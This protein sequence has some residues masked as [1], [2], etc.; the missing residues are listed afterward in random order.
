M[1]V[2]SAGC[3]SDL[4]DKVTSMG[5]IRVVATDFD[6]TVT[7]GGTVSDNVVSSFDRLR[8]DGVVSVLVTGRIREELL[9]EYPGVAEVFDAMVVENGAVAVVGQ[10]AR[11]L[12][13]PVEPDVVAALDAHGIPYRRGQVLL[14]TDATHAGAVLEVI[15]A[16]G[17]DAQ[18]IHNRGQLMVL[19]AGV[20]KGT[21][22]LAVLA[23]LGLSAHNAI[24]IGDAENDLAM[25]EVAEVGVA[26]ANAVPSVRRHADIVLD[27][28]NGEGLAGL[29]AGSFM[30][31]SARWCPPRRWI[32]IGTVSDG[33]VAKV[34]GSQAQIVVSGGSGCG[35]SYLVGLMVE[36]WIEAGYSVLV[37]DPEGDHS[38]LH[39]LHQVHVVDSRSGLPDPRDLVNTLFAPHWSVVVDLSALD[40]ARKTSYMQALRVAAEVH[41]EERGFP[42]W[43][44]VDEAHLLGD[45]EEASW[46]RR[47]GYL[48]SSWRPGLM[49]AADVNCSGI[50][51]DCSANTPPNERGAPSSWHASMTTGSNDPIEFTVSSR[52]TNHVRHRRKYVDRPLPSERRFYFRNSGRVDAP[53][54]AGD[55]TQFRTAINQLSPQVLEYHLGR[56]D[57]SRW[58]GGTIGDR[59]L[60]AQV[61]EWE[62]QLQAH[63]AADLERIRR[64]VVDAVDDRYLS[65]SPVDP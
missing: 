21:G 54:S 43:L 50:V 39:Q 47:G 9:A 61:G 3:P 1:P 26:V 14:A 63:R 64:H 35:K 32:G 37:M 23:D 31:G 40:D 6:G 16:E 33:T 42:H 4:E 45:V 7:T 22:L 34:P 5:F 57:F 44:V 65:I 8:Q 46:M 41:R 55:I 30:T 49:P 52:H 38:P 36:R 27:R 58:I 28:P 24:A 59:E 19:P 56:R 2:L 51:I 29:F 62:D 13:A 17:S 60:A 11:L 25:F 18:L 12:A 15:G 10:R 53:T 20:T 48:L